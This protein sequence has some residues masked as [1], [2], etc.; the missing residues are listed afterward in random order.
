[1][2]EDDNNHKNEDKDDDKNIIH[3]PSLEKRARLEQNKKQEG[4]EQR[5]EDK[6]R[7]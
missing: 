2:S 4:S 1:M 7:H 3:F 5:R 6:K